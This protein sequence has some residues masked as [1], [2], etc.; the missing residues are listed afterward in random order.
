LANAVKKNITDPFSKSRI[1]S[2]LPF[3]DAQWKALTRPYSL[4]VWILL[5]ISIL[6]VSLTHHIVLS[7][8]NWQ[9]QQKTDEQKPVISTTNNTQQL[10]NTSQL[11]G[12]NRSKFLQGPTFLEEF[13]EKIAKPMGK[14]VTSKTSF[15]DSL[16]QTVA[17]LLINKTGLEHKLEAQLASRVSSIIKNLSN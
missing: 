15:V 2:P 7:S 16:L 10:L 3:E 4:I 12:N 17:S 9:T 13:Q 5:P 6:L 1:A 8:V 14:H 11:P